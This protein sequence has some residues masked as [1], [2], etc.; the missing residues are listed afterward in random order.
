MNKKGNIVAALVLCVFILTTLSSCLIRPHVPP[1]Q[2]K[3]H[4]APGHLKRH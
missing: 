4:S 1:G 2:I 3:K